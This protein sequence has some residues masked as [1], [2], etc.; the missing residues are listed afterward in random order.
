MLLGIDGSDCEV[1][2]TNETRERY[3]A[4]KSKKDDVVARIKLSNCF[5]L[6]NKRVLDTLVNSYKYSERKLA[7]KNI[8]EFSKITGDYTIIYIMD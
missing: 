4:E 6:L 8:E 2:N 5:D 3:K 1:P 7:I